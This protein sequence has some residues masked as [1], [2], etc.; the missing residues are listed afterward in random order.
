MA[1]RCLAR[2]GTKPVGDADCHA[3]RVSPKIGRS[4]YVSVLPVGD[5]N[6]GEKVLLPKTAGRLVP[7][8]MDRLLYN[9]PELLDQHQSALSLMCRRYRTVAPSGETDRPMTGA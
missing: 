5:A 7:E 1:N 2:Q 8:E 6:N 9:S 4:R 3:A